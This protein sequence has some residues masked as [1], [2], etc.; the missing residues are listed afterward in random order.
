MVVIGGGILV[1]IAVLVGFT[2]AGGSV[3]AL[4][5]PSEFVTIGGASLGALLIMTPKRVLIDLVRGSIQALKG[6]PYNKKTY[7]ELYRLLFSIGKLVRQE[8]FIALDAH[9]SK[10]DESSLFKEYPLINKNHHAR[11]SLQCPVAVGE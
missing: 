10:P 1:L 9:I 4:I 3:G 2:M 8:G 5:H 11:I 6:S 7:A